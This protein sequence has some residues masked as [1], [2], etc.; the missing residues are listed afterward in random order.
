MLRILY[1]RS[2]YRI[3]REN[4]RQ[5]T[6]EIGNALYKISKDLLIFHKQI[7]SPLV[8]SKLKSMGNVEY[9]VNSDEMRHTKNTFSCEII[10]YPPLSE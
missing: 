2:L 3:P 10:F 1:V 4:V 8:F 9:R 5:I 7:V 6:F